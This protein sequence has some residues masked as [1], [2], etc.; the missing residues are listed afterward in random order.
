MDVSAFRAQIEK[1]EIE[2]EQKNEALAT[3]QGRL[4]VFLSE[5]DDARN[6]KKTLDEREKRVRELELKMQEWDKVRVETSQ[7]RE[8]LGAVVQDV[9][10]AKR[11]LE[12]THTR[13]YLGDTTP[14]SPTFSTVTI[15][16]D[17]SSE[18]SGDDDQLL[19]LQKTHSETLAELESITSKYRDALREIADLAAQISEAKLQ[20]DT[21][22]EVGSDSG[23]S[24]FP[25][26]T[27][28]RGISRR[29]TVDGLSP[30]KVPPSPISIAAAPSRRNLFR[31][32]ASS[33]GLHSRY[34]IRYLLE[35]YFLMTFTQITITIAITGALL[36][37]I[38][39]NFMGSW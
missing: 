4:D 25:P 2:L 29:E 11:S 33:E 19:A 5:Q 28:R 3:L 24:R 30:L 1:V 37:T 27:P 13:V 31:H 16:P 14:T 21:S 17:V 32:A 6:W 38:L 7:E 34:C 36:A 15:K 39:T 23:S 8:R 35:I 20:S 18:R 26:R 9:T 22:S 12:S 10:S